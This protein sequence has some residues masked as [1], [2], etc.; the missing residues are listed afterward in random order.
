MTSQ[1]ATR[2]HEVVPPD[3]SANSTTAVPKTLLTCSHAWTQDQNALL[4]NIVLEK[5]QFDL[6]HNKRKTVAEEVGWAATT[7]LVRSRQ[8]IT[9]EEDKYTD[10]IPLEVKALATQFAGFP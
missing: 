8:A 7:F 9:L 1:D 5:A 6:A 10:K 4:F 3:S 2:L